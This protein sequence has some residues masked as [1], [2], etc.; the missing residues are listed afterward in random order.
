MR[1]GQIRRVNLS[2]YLTPEQSRADF[3]AMQQLEQWH[4]SLNHTDDIDD[5]NMEIRSFHR[6]IYLAGLQLHQMEPALCRHIAESVGRE[7]LTLTT[8][9][10]ELVEQKLLPLQ[11]PA[12]QP[13][14]SGE[15]LDKILQEVAVLK[16]LLEQQKLAMQQLRL[17]TKPSNNQEG[18]RAPTTQEVELDKFDAPT[19]KM[20]KIRQKGIF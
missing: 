1:K 15:Q 8:L 17:T 7:H 19:V 5:A 6:S 16:T 9:M 14:T 3:R 20:Q 4:R 11:L 2:L 12:P 10:Q 13:E 18:P